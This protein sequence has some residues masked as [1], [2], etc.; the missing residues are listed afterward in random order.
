MACGYGPDPTGAI[1]ACLSR[2]TT[3]TSNL[4]ILSLQT[5]WEWPGLGG[6]MST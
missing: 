6:T 2:T 3:S 4:W 1:F 5:M